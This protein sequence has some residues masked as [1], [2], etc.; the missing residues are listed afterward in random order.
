MNNTFLKNLFAP[1]SPSQLS[2]IVRKRIEDGR[3]EVED[4]SGNIFSVFS[5]SVWIPGQRV[6][7]SAGRIV[8]KAGIVPTLKI[9]QV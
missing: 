6:I 5:S 9:Y 4:D 3:Y 7:V 1:A 8:A 2:A